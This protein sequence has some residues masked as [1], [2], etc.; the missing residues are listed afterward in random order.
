MIRI[1]KYSG[2]HVNGGATVRGY[3]ALSCESERA[4]ILV[5]N[6]EYCSKFQVYEVKPDS[7]VPIL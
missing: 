5:P 6:K 2:Q 7:I 1:Q 3:A 4:F